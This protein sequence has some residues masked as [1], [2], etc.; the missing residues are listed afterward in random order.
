M[1]LNAAILGADKA[2]RYTD[3]GPGIPPGAKPLGEYIL[4]PGTGID[5][6]QIIPSGGKTRWKI[7][8]R[9]TDVDT[10]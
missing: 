3:V 5:G 6:N 1:N 8:W 9:E 10:L 7:Y 4:L 2:D